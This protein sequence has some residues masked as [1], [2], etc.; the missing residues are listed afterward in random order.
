MLNQYGLRG[1]YARLCQQNEA[2]GQELAECRRT[3]EIALEKATAEHRLQIKKS[4]AEREQL[5]QKYQALLRQ[6]TAAET[7]LAALQPVM[8]QLNR[9]LQA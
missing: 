2:A 3:A 4:E 9:D 6:K 1:E 7:H 8:E 5:Q